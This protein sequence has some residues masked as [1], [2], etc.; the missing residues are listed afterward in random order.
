[1][2]LQPLL[3]LSNN[4]SKKA[5]SKIGFGFFAQETIVA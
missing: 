1:M 2:P 4:P 5:G 3:W